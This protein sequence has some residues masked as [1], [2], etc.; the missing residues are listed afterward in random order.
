MRLKIKHNTAYYYDNPVSL[1]IHKFYLLPQF[2]TFQKI[3]ESKLNI[4]PQPAGRGDRVDLMGNSF[5][6]V[7]FNTPSK[8]LLV[9][10]ELVVKCVAINPFA[11][12]IE[13]YFIADFGSSDFCGFN[14]KDHSDLSIAGF[15]HFKLN[16]ELEEFVSSIR[17]RST[18]FL[19]FL[20]K[21]TATIHQEWDHLI[22]EEEDFWAPTKTFSL[23]SG[24]C[25]DLAWMLMNLLG[26]LG[27][28]TRFVSGY[29]FNPELESGHELHAWM[30]TFLPGAGWVGLDP[31]L[32]L[33]TNHLY[34]PLAFHAD[35]AKTLP[36]QGTFAGEAK[37]T[38]TTELSISLLDS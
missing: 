5:A 1:G 20:V 34:I 31:S 14:Y 7:W 9:E 10:S 22:R 23:R 35:P 16:P 38:L 17:D 27:L 37:S 15:I 3:L 33:L 6:Q 2:Q 4:Y 29:A 18:N 21:I 13:P 19:D 12:V 8:S 36:V 30:E 32:G 25:R 26:T 28:A 24:S 11:F